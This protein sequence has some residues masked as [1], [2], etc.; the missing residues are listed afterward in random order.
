MKGCFVL[1]Y[2]K[3]K[4]IEEELMDNDFLNTIAEVQ[5]FPECKFSEVEKD[6]E[7]LFNEDV[8]DE[9]TFDN[10]SID[11][12]VGALPETIEYKY[13][14]L[15]GLDMF[16]FIECDDP[17]WVACYKTT[18]G[19]SVYEEDGETLYEALKKLYIKISNNE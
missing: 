15:A 16:Y 6:S 11:D 8:I 9:S 1:F 5:K 12:F 3:I 13:D 7:K 17:H 14:S 2:F 10:W 19:D 4:Y 18:W